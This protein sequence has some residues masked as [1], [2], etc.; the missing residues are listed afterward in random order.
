MAPGRSFARVAWR[1]C[2]SLPTGQIARREFV[3]PA[4]D[5]P[6]VDAPYLLRA[7][8]PAQRLEWDR[9]FGDPP[10]L[11]PAT[12]EII[13]PPTP[14]PDHSTATEPRAAQPTAERLAD[15]ADFVF[16]AP[17]LEESKTTAN[18]SKATTAVA[19]TKTTSAKPATSRNHNFISMPP[20]IRR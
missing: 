11:E 4:D 1:R 5:S 10:V 15:A 7:F 18:P 9:N 2:E 19:N 20:E 12:A 16:V 3:L 6:K 17:T 8:L 13:L 14:T